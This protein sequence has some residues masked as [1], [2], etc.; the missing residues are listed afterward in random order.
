MSSPRIISLLFL[1]LALCQC[2]VN[3]DRVGALLVSPAGEQYQFYSCTQ[4]IASMKT[5]KAGQK[6]LKSRMANAGGFGSVVGGYN[7]DY[8]NQHGMFVAARNAARDKNCEIPAEL[9]VDEPL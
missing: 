7:T 2:A 8:A 6:D 3:D 4:L 9:A 1:L 5:I